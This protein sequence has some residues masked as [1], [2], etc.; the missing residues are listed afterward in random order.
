MINTPESSPSNIKQPNPNHC[1]V[2]GGGFGGMAC[3]LRCRALGLQVTLIERLESLGGRAQVFETN[4]FRHD[5]GPTIITAPF[6]F[7]ELFVLFNENLYDNV[8]F[9]SLSPWYR[10]VFHDG[11]TLD[12]GEDLAELKREIASFSEEDVKGYESLLSASRAMYKVGFEKLSDQPFISLF[13]MIKQIP[14]LFKLRAD[15]TVSQLVNRHVKHPL[16]QQAFSIHPL[17]I[18]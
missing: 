10:Y 15:L 9:K 17:L 6:L 1:I 8:T 14:S 16:L 18:P 13:S 7:E 5:A 4:G 11:R 12:Y 2:I 3:A